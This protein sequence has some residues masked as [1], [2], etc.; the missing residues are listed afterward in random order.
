M[1]ERRNGWMG[2]YKCQKNEE[3]E[4]S[5]SEYCSKMN[6]KYQGLS[7]WYP[8]ENC[9]NLFW[10]YPSK[11]RNEILKFVLQR[12]NFYLR[13]YGPH[14]SELVAIHSSVTDS[15]PSVKVMW[16]GWDPNSRTL[17]HCRLCYF[18]QHTF[19]EIRHKL[20]HVSAPSLIAWMRLGPL[21]VN[22]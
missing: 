7:D 12:E 17:V 14:L 3:N 21:A 9:N 15:C 13:V 16:P 22:V 5:C 11:F 4:C 1:K 10:F 18:S 19:A 6:L 2:G 20:T 8:S